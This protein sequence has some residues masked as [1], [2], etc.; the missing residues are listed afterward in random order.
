MDDYSSLRRLKLVLKRDSWAINPLWRQNQ[1][2]ATA[3]WLAKAAGVNVVTV[4]SKSNHEFRRAFAEYHVLDY[5][6][7]IDLMQSTCYDFSWYINVCRAVATDYAA[8]SPANMQMKYKPWRF[9]SNWAISKR[10]FRTML[11]QRR[12]LPRSP[13]QFS[14]RVAQ[15]SQRHRH[16]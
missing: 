3:I 8:D 12:R 16:T 6:D 11:C 5:K 7:K 15:T 10:V 1:G 4:R 14:I 2:R 13:L 9:P